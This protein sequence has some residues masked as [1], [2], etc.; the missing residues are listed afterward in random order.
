MEWGK[1]MK[2]YILALIFF[3]FTDIIL[4][5]WVTWASF[6]L[7]VVTGFL[8]VHIINLL[9]SSWEA[10]ETPSLGEKEM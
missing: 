7:M 3:P 9:S 6:F 4:H 1:N 2:N 5:L 8:S 10:T